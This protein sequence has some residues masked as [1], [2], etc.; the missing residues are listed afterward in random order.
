MYIE[1]Q[2][3]RYCSVHAIN[4]LFGC[5][6]VTCLQ[7]QKF[8]EK[9]FKSYAYANNGFFSL[10]II[11]KWLTIKRKRTLRQFAVMKNNQSKKDKL[12]MIG[13]RERFLVTVRH[14][15]GHIYTVV[16]ENSIFYVLDSEKNTITEVDWNK[17]NGT[18]YELI[19]YTKPNKNASIIIVN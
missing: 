12:E 19:K 3:K 1:K 15:Y 9:Y 18:L 5:R 8:A 10:D 14:P 16:K 2:Y 4:A 17:L 6:I 7:M 13:N 11:K